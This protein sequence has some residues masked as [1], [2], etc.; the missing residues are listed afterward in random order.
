MQYAVRLVP[1]RQLGAVLALCVALLVTGV[2]KAD[3]TAEL[4][5]V[6]R[7]VTLI[8]ACTAAFAVHD[9]A[10]TV[11][12]ATRQGR[13]RLRT[14]AGA[15][16]F[17]PVAGAWLG[18]MLVPGAAGGPSMT[19]IVPG[20]FVELAALFAF[21]LA[22]ASRMEHAT[23]MDR[24]APWSAVMLVATTLATVV[25]ASTRAWLWTD[26]GPQWQRAHVR[27]AGLTIFALV[28]FLQLS[29]DPA[30]R[31]TRLTVN[32]RGHTTRQRAQSPL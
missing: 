30:R 32:R 8:F 23:P 13:C 6:M 11:T 21:G 3:S 27:W 14:A 10:G 7:M 24:A 15:L 20:L 16:A 18:L 12:E 1:W 17:L 2:P 5:P 29:R 25:H 4:L 31:V 9:P 28:T 26:P 22:I 19:S